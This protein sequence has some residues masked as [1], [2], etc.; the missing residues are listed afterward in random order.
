MFEMSGRNIDCLFIGSNYMKLE[1]TEKLMRLADSGSYREFNFEFVQHNQKLYSLAELYNNFRYGS[2]DITVGSIF[3]ATI[4][5][6]ANYLHN[7]GLTFDYVNSFREEREEL[8]DMLKTCNIQTIAI[9]TTLYVTLQPILEIVSF[10]RKYNNTAKI[11]IGGPFIFNLLIED[12]EAEEQANLFDRINGDFYIYSAQGEKALVNLI[13]RIK[14]KSNSFEDIENLFYKQGTKYIKTANVP[15]NNSLEDNMVD[16]TLFSSKM[17]ESI[18]VRTSISCPFSCSYCEYPIRNGKYRTASVAA[19][20]RELNSIAQIDK[21]KNVYFIDD[22]L[23][24]PPQRFKD[25]LRMMIKNKYKFKW[26]SFFRCQFADREM[27]ELMK[28]SGCIMLFLGIESGNQMILDRMNKNATLDVFRKGL[29][30]INEFEIPSTASFV[31]GFPGETEETINETIQFIEET[32]PTFYAMNLWYFSKFSAIANQRDKYDL[33]GSEYGW[34]HHTMD[35]KTAVGLM[36]KMLLTIKNSIHLPKYNFDNTGI[37][38]LFNQGMS[39]EQV[40]NLVSA[41][42]N[43]IEQKLLD[44]NNVEFSRSLIDRMISQFPEPI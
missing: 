12:N 32:K 34:S 16:W 37:L 22:T 4:A 43:G 42:N 19:V 26:G 14:S 38:N 30:L 31:I 21:I 10:V 24:F 39:I 7:R 17:K 8:I 35:C 40:K 15:E 2:N 33:K 11:V 13:N 44:T 41:F 3:S 27:I 36:E 5:Y 1:E 23:N 9:P 18:L 6:L 28:E 29:Q 25:I 20:E